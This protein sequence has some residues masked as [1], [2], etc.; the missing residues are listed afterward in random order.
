MSLMQ[1]DLK[2]A[3]LIEQIMYRAAEQ[4]GDI[5]AP[6]M[7][8]YYQRFPDAVACFEKLGNGDRGL[9]E[10]QMVENSVFCL[11]RWYESPFEVKVLISESL[12][13]HEETLEIV[14][15]WYIELIRMVSELIGE[16][17]PETHYEEQQAWQEVSAALTQVMEE[18]CLQAQAA[19]SE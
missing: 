2:K 6:V 12:R 13:H 19:Q 10:G 5:T 4:I 9:L 15:Q 18:T 16:T 14:F 7:E 8:R 3:A 11:M 1:V 17:I